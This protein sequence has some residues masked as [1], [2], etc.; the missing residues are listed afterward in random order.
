FI[1]LLVLFRAV[2]VAHTA[3]AAEL[4]SAIW[5]ALVLASFVGWGSGLN[6][7][8]F[9][10]RR[11]DLGLRCAWGWGL[12]VGI[13]GVLLGLRPARRGVVVGFVALGLLLLHAEVAS[14]CLRWARGTRWLRWRRVVLLAAD[15]PFLA[16]AAAI[17]GLGA[18]RAFA[19]LLNTRYN[20]ND[21][22]L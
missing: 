4:A 9:P 20:P 3:R 2:V 17:S 6:A 10:R 13:G 16:G 8:L 14:V 11:A 22:N 19:A 12:A 18:L 21:D 1:V 15:A 5:G 7:W